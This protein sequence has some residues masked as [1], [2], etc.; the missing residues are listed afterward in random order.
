MSV[1]VCTE[2]KQVQASMYLVCTLIVWW[3]TGL[4]AQLL[5]LCMLGHQLSEAKQDWVCSWTCSPID[6]VRYTGISASVAWVHLQDCTSCPVLVAHKAGW[7]AVWNGS[8]SCS[9]NS[10]GVWCVQDA[11]LFFSCLEEGWWCLKWSVSWIDMSTYLFKHS[12][13]FSPQVRT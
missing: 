1:L 3:W 4:C 9:A 13:Y 8:L 7:V 10:S 2:Y 12:T 6:H 11:I 5:G